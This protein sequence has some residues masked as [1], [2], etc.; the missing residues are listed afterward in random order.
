M[1]Q[2][3]SVAQ[4]GHL[5]AAWRQNKLAKRSWRWYANPL[6][7]HTHGAASLEEI[8]HLVHLVADSICWADAI[9]AIVRVVLLLGHVW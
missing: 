6:V 9:A 1:V 5:P 4:I 8:R 7:S 2:S 3:P